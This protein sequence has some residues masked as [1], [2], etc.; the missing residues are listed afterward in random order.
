MKHVPTFCRICEVEC[1]VIATVEDGRITDVKADKKNP[2]SRGFMCT[3]ARAMVDVVY[4]PDRILTPMK[5]VGAPGEF[6]PCTWD[7]ALDD[8]AARLKRIIGDHGANAFAVYAGNPASFTT[9]GPVAVTGLRDAVGGA[10]CYGVNGEDH[11]ASWPRWRCSTAPAGWHCGPICG[12]PTS[13]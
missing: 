8:I 10:P 11:G 5:R 1:G 12:G 6:E 7:E 13:C 4:D 9:A 3:K 2:H